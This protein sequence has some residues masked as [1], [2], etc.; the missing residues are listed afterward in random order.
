MAYLLQFSDR[1]RELFTYSWSISSSAHPDL[2]KNRMN[3]EPSQVV[4]VALTF[5]LCAYM[6]HTY[7]TSTSAS[8]SPRYIQLALPAKVIRYTPRRVTM[9][10][11]IRPEGCIRNKPCSYN[12]H[13]PCSYNQ[14]TATL[15]KFN[16]CESNQ[17]NYFQSRSSCLIGVQLTPNTQVQ[18][19]VLLLLL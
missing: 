16:V 8:H 6:G 13:Q 17:L 5:V 4:T 10:C 7:T 1:P 15:G 18:S 11:N 12:Q 14:H 3:S 2:H 9:M 19:A